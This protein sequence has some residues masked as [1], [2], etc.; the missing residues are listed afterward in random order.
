MAEHE[1]QS[2]QNDS[3]ESTQR[4]ALKEA[5]RLTATAEAH[6]R[7]VELR[8][9]SARFLDE[10]GESEQA[11]VERREANLERDA[12]RTAWD[13]AHA[14]QGPTQVTEAGLEIPIPTREH[15][16]RNLEKVAPPAP[17]R[18]ASRGRGA[19]GFPTS[20]ALESQNQR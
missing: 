10:L 12:A 9:E 15:F 13:R 17:S 1:P 6:E 3:D 14:L 2:T 16:L 4:N 18:D 7:R 19:D 8:E 11:A 5:K 20:R